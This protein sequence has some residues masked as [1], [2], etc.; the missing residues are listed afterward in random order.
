MD[1]SIFFEEQQKL[2]NKTEVSKKRYLYE[3]ISWTS[4]CIAILGQRGTGKTT[5]MLQ[6]IKEYFDASPKALYVSVDNPFFKT[7][8][9][10]EFALD[11]EKLGGEVLFIDEVHKY[12]E[13]SS[14]IKAIYDMSSLKVVFSG[15][16]MIQ[17][18]EQDADLS[19][20]VDSY[21]L[22]NLSFREYL[23]IMD[24]GSFEPCSLKELFADHVKIASGVSKQIKP[25]QHF[26][27][28]LEFGCY[29][30][31]VEGE[32]RYGQKLI[33]IINQIVESDL[34]YVKKINFSQIDK[35]KKLVYVLA[36]S[37][38]FTP[39]ITKLA[40]AT[41]ISRVTMSEYLYYLELASIVNSLSF[42]ARGYKKIEKP[43]KLYL[44]NTNLMLAISKD[45]NIGNKRETFF[46]NQ[47]KSYFY[48][49]ASF[50][51]ENILLSTTGDFL[52][53]QKY[54]VE[55]GGK[56]KSYK[57][58]QDVENSYVIADEIEIGF[59]NKVPLWMFG[60]LY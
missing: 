16:S 25:L 59:G 20:R 39:N 56:N 44:Y 49:R 43:D 54:V 8:S 7:I 33:G 3:Q 15:S 45:A 53:E 21:K 9:L 2:L 10:Y 19:R 37:V 57:Q 48:N 23:H 51:D 17:I 34:P 52:L 12:S 4:R 58:I 24:I 41:D 28:Y 30:F 11:F 50:L 60:F 32:D 27:D 14:H 47:M 1:L 40:L 18:Q 46:V 6:H 26:R 13:W 55:I 22:A 35:I 5:L 42:K 29:P 31:I 36:T 38:P